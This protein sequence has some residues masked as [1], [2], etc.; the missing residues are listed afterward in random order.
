MNTLMLSYHPIIGHAAV[1]G[2]ASS[3]NMAAVQKHI[4]AAL[5]N[6]MDILPGRTS[7]GYH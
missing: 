7:V 3:P 5:M 1:L 6:N 2:R 4:R